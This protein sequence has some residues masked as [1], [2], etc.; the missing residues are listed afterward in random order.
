MY[1]HMLCKIRL[2]ARAPA[3]RESGGYHNEHSLFV[4]TIAWRG[5]IRS[6]LSCSGLPLRSSCIS[7]RSGN[8]CKYGGAPWLLC[9]RQ[10]LALPEAL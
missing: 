6:H 3:E 1:V 9:V 5:V 2:G 7:P 8:F 10:G 4:E